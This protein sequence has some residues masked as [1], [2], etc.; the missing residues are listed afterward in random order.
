MSNPR[1]QAAALALLL[2]AA[3]TLRD[4]HATTAERVRIADQIQRFLDDPTVPARVRILHKFKPTLA[5]DPTTIRQ[6]DFV[7]E[8]VDLAWAIGFD[9]W[10]PDDVR[11][12]L[13]AHEVCRVCFP[14]APKPV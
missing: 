2:A 1:E 11:E 6:E 12:R 13:P 9:D 8:K 7:C 4:P 3:S 5:D 10:P 14:D